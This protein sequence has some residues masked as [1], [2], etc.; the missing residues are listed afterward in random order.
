M[1]GERPEAAAETAAAWDG[2]V[3]L[4]RVARVLLGNLGALIGLPLSMAV[5]FVGTALLGGP[6]YTTNASFITLQASEDQISGAL[7]L[8]AAQLGFL[9]ATPSQS[10]AFYADLLISRELLGNVARREY[11]DSSREGGDA[12]AHLARRLRVRE[13]SPPLRLEKTIDALEDVLR[14]TADNQT[15][16]V[17]L[18]VTTREPALSQ[19]L[20]ENLLVAIGEFDRETRRSQASAEREF[21]ESQRALAEQDLLIA[22]DSLQA[23]LQNNRRW[24]N[25]PGLTFEHD[26][27]QRRVDLRQQLYVQLN[28]SYERA[29]IEEVRNTPVVTVLEQ[30]RA[31]VRPD[32]G[33]ILIR[34]FLGLAAGLG[35]ALAWVCGRELLREERARDPALYEGVA[36]AARGRFEGLRRI[37]RRSRS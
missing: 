11:G 16:V 33:R 13:S 37:G 30:P 20:A 17:T 25:S 8:A 28:Q 22:E 32:A 7:P 1:T 29:R 5:V 19:A 15:G 27:L 34:L 9:Q 36:S 10:P 12:T 26:R 21:V 14:V 24:E 3:S 2:G 4:L 35:L 18:S 6:R 31:P 23:F